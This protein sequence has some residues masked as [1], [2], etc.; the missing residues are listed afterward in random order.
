MKRYRVYSIS[1]EGFLI[2]TCINSGS[3][4]DAIERFRRAFP[5]NELVDLCEHWDQHRVVKI[6]GKSRKLLKERRIAKA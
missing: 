6:K 2:Q 4:D 3:K 1:K 5:K